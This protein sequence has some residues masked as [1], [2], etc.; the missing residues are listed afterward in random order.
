MSALSGREYY[1]AK[2]AS[3]HGDQG[4]GT[5][6]GYPIR[7]VQRGFGEWVIKNGRTGG[8]FTSDMPAYPNITDTQLDEMITWLDSFDHPT[9]G[10]RLYVAF[11]GNCHGELGLGGYSGKKI[12]SRQNSTEEIRNGKGGTDYGSRTLYMPSW[13]TTELSGNE[14]M[15]INTF[16]SSLQDQ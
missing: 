2:C 11:C 16:V 3:C 12:A 9:S 1:D 5:P 4:E 14:V 6:K 13:S 7:F 10:D 15:N 8:E